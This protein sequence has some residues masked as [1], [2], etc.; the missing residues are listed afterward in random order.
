VVDAFFLPGGA[1]FALL[2][3]TGGQRLRS[4]MSSLDRRSARPLRLDEGTSRR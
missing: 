2:G 1:L 3:S 4:L